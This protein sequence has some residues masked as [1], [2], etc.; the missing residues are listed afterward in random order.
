MVQMKRP[1]S[2]EGQDGLHQN[3]CSS[4]NFD[5]KLKKLISFVKEVGATSDSRKV[6]HVDRL[7]F[8]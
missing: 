5:Q 4:H 3:E 8:N 7:K 2:L 6:I 1:M